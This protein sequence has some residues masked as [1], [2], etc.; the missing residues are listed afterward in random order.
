MSYHLIDCLQRI[1]HPRILVLGDLILDRYVWG[2]AERISQEAPVILLRQQQ[3]EN[4][5]GGAANV[6]N[7]VRGLDAEVVMAGVIGA[8]AD[9]QHMRLALEASG[10][11]ASCVLVDPSR[12]T[13]VKERYL[14]RAHNRHPH[15]IL[16]VD[17]EV[18]TP[19]DNTLSSDLLKMML[20][21]LDQFDAILVSD[22]A[23]GVCTVKT[24]PPLIQAARAKKI[25]LIV[26]PS[27]TGKCELFRHAT[28]ITP[29]RTE[30]RLA[31]GQPMQTLDQAFAAGRQL[32]QELSLDYIYV[33]LDAQG[34]ALVMADGHA[35]LLPTRKRDVCD[36]TGAGDM[37]LAMVGIG[38]AAGL[39]PDDLGHLANIAG[40]L[41]V[42]QVGVVSISRDQ[43]L[44][45]LLR[46]ARSI[47]DKSLTLGEV[48]QHV[49]AR[50]RLGQKI[51]MTNGCF[52][53]LHAGHVTYLQQAA[54][55]GDCL[56]VAIN[57]D[58]SVRGLD[59]GSDRPIFGQEHRAAMIAALEAVDYVVVFS[60]ATPHNVIRQLKPD[61][62][63]KGGTYSKDEI[64]GRELVE[65]YGGCVKPM[66]LVP[67]ISTTEILERMRT[68]QGEPI[69]IPLPQPAVASKQERKAG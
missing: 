49:E 40:G 30:T 36:I 1:Q 29:N 46:G 31:T 64:V 47:E 28:A 20:A 22:Y 23:K 68:G 13:T 26:D 54:A 39:P 34:I 52:D 10:V 11:D 37:V 66:G 45:D 24:V 65:T 57:S 3:Q 9:G 2:E 60:E 38:M 42:E 32:V 33:T 35:E 16:R 69:I 12:P 25:P 41:E 58:D 19:L 6:A 17:R 8:D 61:V 21:K 48:S 50:R 59:K 44:A 14:G 63:V 51:V 62:L 7:M 5:L 15:Q 56:V 18:R 27:S 43:I 4:R 53:V 67:G 55:E